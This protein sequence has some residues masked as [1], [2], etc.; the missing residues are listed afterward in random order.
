MLKRKISA[1]VAMVLVGSLY[2]ISAQ[3]GDTM[4]KL[5]DALHDSGSISSDAYIALKA[6]AE[7]ESIGKRPVNAEVKNAIAEEVLKVSKT[8]EENAN[9]H[10]PTDA[11]V[12]YKDG[13]KLESADGQHSLGINGRLQLDSRNFLNDTAADVFDL[14]RAYLIFSGK[15]FNKFEYNMIGA[16]NGKNTA[17]PIF[18]DVNYHIWDEFQIKMGQLRF[19]FGQNER[20]SSRN[21]D[22]MERAMPMQFVPGIDRG[23]MVHGNPKP[24]IYYA[25]AVVNGGFRQNAGFASTQQDEFTDADGKDVLG[26]L[27]I[28][29]AKMLGNKDNIYHV[30]VAYGYGIQPGQGSFQ[31]ASTEARG[32]RFFKTAD[33]DNSE[34]KLQRFGFDS[35]LAFGP[36]K[37]TGEYVQN[38]YN[39]ESLKGV[40]F[41]RSLDTYYLSAN[42]MITGENY[43]QY[44]GKD[45]GFGN[46]KPNHNFDL[47]GGL[48]AWEL[49]A[50]FSHLDASDFKTTNAVGTGVLSKGSANQADA[51]TIGLKWY[52]N[53]NVRFYMEYVK[54]D[55]N[56]PV[57][58]QGQAGA[59]KAGT[60]TIGT[61]TS[62]DALNFSTRFDF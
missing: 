53:P 59:G 58:I 60:K 56:M 54:T 24:G 42:W 27:A 26:R 13:F 15:V 36:V 10:S 2:M 5:I 21:L 22:F 8:V 45:G 48:G 39:G 50:R 46:I 61:A 1:K 19:P 20:T 47:S 49:A 52:L 18:W 40:D 30:G 44:F 16:F 37:F 38:I 31:Q 32:L 11:K 29:A 14:R 4:S 55:F 6:S 43:S 28:D 7:A 51:Y 41:D 57:D 23:V 34:F 33:F 25:G 12:I 17:Q 9:K 62:E 3:A 35:T